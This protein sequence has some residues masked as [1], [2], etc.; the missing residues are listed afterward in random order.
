[1]LEFTNNEVY[2]AAQGLTYWWINSQSVPGPAW[3]PTPAETVFRDTRIW[4]VFNVGVYHYPSDRITFDGLTI[5]GA[6][7]RGVSAC[8]T[9]GHFGSDYGM[10]DL[11]I[12]RADIQGMGRGID[13]SMRANGPMTIEDSVF[14]NEQDI[15]TA[16]MWNVN[17]G[18]NVVPRLVTVRNSRFAAWPGSVASS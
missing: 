17:G 7:P 4:H 2:S 1:M 5:R 10:K 6:Y 3:N 8:C 14:R 15:V 12:R 16:T 9:V 18:G 11:V 13:V